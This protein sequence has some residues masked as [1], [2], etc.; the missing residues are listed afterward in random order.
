MVIYPL[1]KD[2]LEENKLH[3]DTNAFMKN[4]KFNVART[5]FSC[6]HLR[7]YKVKHGLLEQVLCGCSIV[8]DKSDGKIITQPN[9]LCCCSQY[10]KMEQYV[11]KRDIRCGSGFPV[12]RTPEITVSSNGEEEEVVTYKGGVSADVLETPKFIIE[13]IP[14]GN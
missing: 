7:R 8:F 3:E 1:L 9:C 10:E 14:F 11:N 6:K 5:C 12:K 4:M 13:D 2:V